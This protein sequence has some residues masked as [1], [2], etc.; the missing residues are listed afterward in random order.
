[1]DA[2]KAEDTPLAVIV[3]PWRKG[4]K[5]RLY[6]KDARTK[7]TLG[8]VDPDTYQGRLNDITRG[9]EFIAVLYKDFA[10]PHEALVRVYLQSVPTENKDLALNQPGAAAKQKAEDIRAG[11]SPAHAKIVRSLGYGSPEQT[12]EQGAEGERI[13]GQA[14]NFGVPDSWKV[15]HSVPIGEE[16]SDIDHLVI[17]NNGIFTINTKSHP[18]SRV[19]CAENQVKVLGKT[20][21]KYHPY[22]RNARYEAKRAGNILSAAT[23]LDIQVTGLV[24]YICQHL[25]IMAHPKDGKVFHVGADKLV[26]FLLS[27]HQ[28]YPDRYVDLVY[29]KARW[30][31][32]WTEADYGAASRARRKQ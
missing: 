32:T 26:S 17:G 28:M 10:I 5:T 18:G 16:E 19:I 6:V 30:S 11:M 27:K 22:A 20:L 23:G 4:G 3:T 24:A 13:V 14:L 1:M 7:D 9:V 15:L 8:W 12:W 31:R 2:Q 21:S 29:D 25:D